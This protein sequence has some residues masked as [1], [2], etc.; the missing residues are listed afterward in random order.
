MTQLSNTALEHLRRIADQ[1][2]LSATRYEMIELLGRGGMGSV[3]LVRDRELDRL[4]ALKVLVT[5]GATPDLV[6]RLVAEARIL[7]SLEHPGIVPV[8]DVGTTAE[9][10][11]FYTMKLVRGKRLDRH[12]TAGISMAERIRITGQI[13]D[14]VAFAH[15]R[16]VLHR[17]LKPTNIMI[18][19]FGEVLVMDWGLAR[20]HR[21]ADDGPQG[22]SNGTSA[23]VGTPGFMAPEQSGGDEA[24]VDERADVYGI[25]GILR[26]LLA[27][28]EAS[29]PLR[30]IAERAMALRPA[31]RYPTVASLAGDIDRYLSNLPVSAYQETL[32]EKAR[33]L[34]TRHRLPLGLI[35][36]YLLMRLLLLVLA[37][38]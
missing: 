5:G 18:G 29:R 28:T 20:L 10:L 30:A 33:R 4:V 3:Y 6:D 16:N 11:P 32:V 31:E 35:V 36:A 2:D 38:G 19:P 7:A 9:S 21:T 25:G 15:A 37:R 1:P 17:D 23:V 22:G 27:G 8:H 34:V 26:F 13:C 14:A 24:L 12:V